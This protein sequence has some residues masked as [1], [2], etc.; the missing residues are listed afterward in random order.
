MD[1]VLWGAK[2]IGT[3]INQTERQTHHLLET[4]A[5]K[6]APKVG[7]RWCASLSGLR[8]QFGGELSEAERD[9]ATAQMKRNAPAWESG[10]LQRKPL[11]G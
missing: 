7:A 11:A 10:A 1:K 8:E 4:G 9:D 6:A 2:A 5:I 3:T